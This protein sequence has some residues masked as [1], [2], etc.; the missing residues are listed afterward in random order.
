M[1]MDNIKVSAKNKKDLETLI[2]AMRIYSQN[3]R[4]EFGVEK[5]AM[6]VMK[7]VK[8]HLTDGMEQPNQEKIKTLGEKKTYKY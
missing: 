6:L 4:K 3:I 7:N 5:R 8:R 2:H 1:Y